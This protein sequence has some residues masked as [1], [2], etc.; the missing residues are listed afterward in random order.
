MGPENEA[1]IKAKLMELRAF[2]TAA[3]LKR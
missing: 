1:A 2:V 3:P